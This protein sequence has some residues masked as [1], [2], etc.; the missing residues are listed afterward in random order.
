[1]LACIVMFAAIAVNTIGLPQSEK[2]YVTCAA[3]ILTLCPVI[4][5]I[6]MAVGVWGG[7]MMFLDT[8]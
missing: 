2:L 6:I 1:M 7:I 8:D 5:T 4:N 3:V